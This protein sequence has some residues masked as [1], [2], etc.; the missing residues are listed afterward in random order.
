MRIAF[1]TSAE[2]RHGYSDDEHAV[3]ALAERGCRVEHVVWTEATLRSLGSFDG[4]VVR[5][6]WDWYENPR[7]FERFLSLLGQVRVPVVNSPSVLTEFLDKAY[8]KRLERGG[9]TCIPTAWFRA[10]DFSRL[11]ETMDANSWNDCIL[12]PSNSANAFGAQRFVL[13]DAARVIAEASRLAARFGFDEFMLQPFVPQIH[14]GEW[15]VVIFDGEY[16][17]ACLKIPKAGDHRVQSDHGGSVEVREPAPFVIEAAV[18]AAKLISPTLAYARID[19]IVADDRFLL[20]EAEV[21]EPELFFRV[22]ADAAPRFANAVLKR[23]TRS[24]C[25]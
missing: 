12:K 6:T 11:T 5:S 7:E 22:S 16:S 18:N 1:L 8:L 19:G 13:A 10:S 15:A 25:G 20:M 24:M 23:V 4:V 9:V 21:V 14:F 2:L 3:H 17:H